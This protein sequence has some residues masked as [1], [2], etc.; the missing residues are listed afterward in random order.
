MF[1]DP[2]SV[3]TDPVWHGLKIG[4]WATWVAGGA[5]FLAVCVAVGVPVVQG[6]L[7]RRERRAHENET[8]RILA[9]EINAV[10]GSFLSQMLDRRKIIQTAL[11]G[12]YNG[13]AAVFSTYVKIWGLDDLPR[14]GDLQGL[15]YPVA[16]SIASLR[17]YLTM[18]NGLIDRAVGLIDMKPLNRSIHELD[19]AR[20]LDAA[21]AALARAA[22]HLGKYDQTYGYVNYFDDGNGGKILPLRDYD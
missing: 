3:C 22:G 10:M 14:G 13:N 1:P 19:V 17:A 5:T 9:I 18:Y 11:S 7:Q 6:F 20:M 16:P 12:T 8:A 4:D 15:P 21:Q 2:A